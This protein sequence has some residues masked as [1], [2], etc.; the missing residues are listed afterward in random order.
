VTLKFVQYATGRRKGSRCVRNRRTGRRC[1]I[2]LLR[3]TLV[4][5]GRSGTNRLRFQGRISRRRK[6]KPG[7]Y[8]LLVSAKD[9]A[10]N[11][12]KTKQTTLTLVR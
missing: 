11:V 9:A 1:R 5:S 8:T 12:A 2:T 7:R 6:L 4:V 10:G 3:G